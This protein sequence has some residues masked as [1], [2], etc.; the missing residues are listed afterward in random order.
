MKR[1]I[2]IIS[3]LFA[4]ALGSAGCGKS[5]RASRT[6]EIQLAY[7]SA[8]QESVA[9]YPRYGDSLKASVKKANAAVRAELARLGQP[10]QAFK[11]IAEA[12]NADREPIFHADDPDCEVIADCSPTG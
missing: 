11:M 4:N 9:N 5:L 12:T 2:I 7:V 6:A 8:L 1:E 3:L 10:E